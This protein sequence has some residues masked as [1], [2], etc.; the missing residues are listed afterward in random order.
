[1]VAERMDKLMSEPARSFRELRVYQLARE[2]NREL[3]E[4]TKSFPKD[5][6]YSLTDQIRR[7]GRAAKN[8][9][10]EAW[11]HRRSP[12]AF[13]SKLTGALGEAMEAQG[14][15]DDAFDYGYI[16][17]TQFAKLD[18]GF[19]SIGAMLNTMIAGAESFVPPP[20]RKSDAASRNSR[21]LPP[22]TIHHPPSTL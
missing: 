1:M 2:I 18:A 5:E 9:I 17:K 19:Q 4:V 15:L 3:F 12:A 13:A 14:W 8:L 6:R 16:T 11:G 7:S 10:P 22:S 21:P 20:Y